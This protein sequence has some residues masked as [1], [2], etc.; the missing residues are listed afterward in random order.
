MPSKPSEEEEKLSMRMF[1]DEFLSLL[2]ERLPELPEEEVD[3]LAQKIIAMT[4]DEVV[5]EVTAVSPS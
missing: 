5:E 3:S 1:C 4:R 2:K